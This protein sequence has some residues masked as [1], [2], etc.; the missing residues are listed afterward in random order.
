[1]RLT[2]GGEIYRSLL[3]SWTCYE[4]AVTTLLAL[5]DEVIE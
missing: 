5:A 2:I 3:G 4:T 1:M